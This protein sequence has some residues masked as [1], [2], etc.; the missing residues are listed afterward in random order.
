MYA[1]VMVS[2]AEKCLSFSGFTAA[3]KLWLS[4]AGKRIGDGRYSNLRGVVW[5]QVFH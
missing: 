5:I 2:I 3:A 1:R 4:M